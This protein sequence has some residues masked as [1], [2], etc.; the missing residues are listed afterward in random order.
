MTMYFSNKIL[1]STNNLLQRMNTTTKYSENAT[2]TRFKSEMTPS[3][4]INGNISLMNEDKF[5]K[6]LSKEELLKGN[7]IINL[8]EPN[9]AITFSKETGRIQKISP[10]ESWWKVGDYIPTIQKALK[11]AEKNFNNKS[12]V[13]KELVNL[14]GITEK[15]IKEA[16]SVGA[17]IVIP[18]KPKSR[19]EKFFEKLDNLLNF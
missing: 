15:G 8:R 10:S 16:K 3:I 14:D 13:K 9:I 7:A 18:Q 5:V 6:Q 12:I 2:K 19:I 1:K 11:S 17:N 4:L